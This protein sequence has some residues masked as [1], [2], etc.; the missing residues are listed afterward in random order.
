MPHQSDCGIALCLCDSTTFLIYLQAASLNAIPPTVTH[1]S[2][3]SVAWSVRLSVC[4][5]VMHVA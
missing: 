2:H 1:F 4:H 5:I 3:F